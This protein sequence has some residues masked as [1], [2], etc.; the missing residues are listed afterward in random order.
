[1]FGIFAVVKT[2]LFFGGL[3]G[4][5]HLGETFAAWTT[6]SPWDIVIITSNAT[7]GK[8]TFEFVPRVDLDTGTKIYF[9]DNGWS[10]STRR[11]NEWVIT[12]TG[13][14]IIP[15]GTAIMISWTTVYP[16]WRWVASMTPTNG[17]VPASVDT[18]LAYQ[19]TSTWSLPPSFVYGIG[20]SGAWT[21][22]I[23]NNSNNSNIPST[24]ASGTT[25]VSLPYK[26]SQYLC[27]NT[28]LSSSSFLADISN[29][30]N[31]TGNAVTAYWTSS[32]VFSVIQMPVWTITY[33]PSTPTTGGVIATINFNKTGV[34]IDN[35]WWFSWYTFTG[36]GDFTFTFHD[37]Y[38]NTWSTTASVYWIE[39][40]AG[41]WTVLHTWDIVIV[42]ADSTNPD[43]FE[44]VSRVDLTPGTK[45]YFSDDAWSGDT[46]RTAEWALRFI[47]TSTI[48]A[49]NPVYFEWWDLTTHPEIRT[50]FNR[51][52]AQFDLSMNGD[53]I[54]I[55]Q[56]ATFDAPDNF[57]FGVGFGSWWER[58]DTGTVIPTP[59][60][61]Y[62]P[63]D[64]ELNITAD[65]WLPYK[66][67][68]YTC[69]NKG[70]RSSWFLADI[71]STGN[72]TG[73]DSRYWP[74]SNC[75]LD[76]NKPQVTITTWLTQQ[77]P[78]S[79]TS[80]KFI[81]TF[82]EPI[83]IGTFDC[84]N[85]TLTWT[86][87]TKTCN[88]ITEIGPNDGTTFEIDIAVA[89]DGTVIAEIYSGQVLDINN[90][91]NDDFV[92]IH[93]IVTLDNTA[94]ILSW[95]LPSV[96]NTTVSFNFTSNEI[97][98]IAY[99][100]MCWNGSLS[101][102]ISGTNSTTFTLA[103]TTYSW[104]QLNVTD[105][106]GNT[107]ARLSIPTFIV[108]YTAPTWGGGWGW[109]S[110][111][112]SKDNCPDGDYS[113][114]YYD[115]TCGKKTTTSSHGAAT[116]TTASNK[117]LTRK[118]LANLS[119]IFAQEVLELEA[120][121]SL[122]CTFSD[123]KNESSTTKLILA[124]VCQLGIMWVNKDGTTPLKKF[125]PN[126]TVARNEF[127]AVISRLLFDDKNNLSLASLSPWYDKHTS[128]LKNIKLLSIIPTRIT[129]AVAIDVFN[130]IKENTDI[131]DR[132]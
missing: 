86:V 27:T 65:E 52:S 35:N 66:N 49:W 29:P 89:G 3:L 77:S 92:A 19:G 14:K 74:I 56:W 46:R 39:W 62:I 83:Q 37:D 93:N 118:V 91:P 23:I 99:S 71:A 57:I 130:Y 117:I 64:L 94:P 88:G 128:A 111:S 121:T 34:T 58:V 68:Q 44:F 18:I 81:A 20:R 124:K 75:T 123:T 21:G 6:L 38:G 13:S 31:W 9:T 107:S 61:S 70:M 47:A 112:I 7:V 54:F 12:F 114:S 36:N 69:N 132:D 82:S 53:N 51:G 113:P 120:D 80:V 84:S 32:C 108:N 43:A 60:R 131:I 125:R 24:L 59:Q 72:W 122:W 42:T 76:A 15:A 85:I 17:F 100:W 103:N 110:S 115:D 2:I 22:G 105:I 25:V 109:G 1:M 4:L 28:N 127:I 73:G 5:I 116:T 10:G 129:Q 40:S 90:N 119:M 106:A 101:T 79:W 104:C 63:A 55:Y 30:A 26:N 78:T 102:D 126:D 67:V 33:D 95:S 96:A 97:W 16:S 11:A 50:S 45:I 48:V 87:G 98:S 8:W 41:S